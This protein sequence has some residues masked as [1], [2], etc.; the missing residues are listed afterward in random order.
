MQIE[1]T[2]TN[3][4]VRCAALV[5]I[6]L[7]SASVMAADELDLRTE[8]ILRWFPTNT[9]ALAVINGEYD[10]SRT[11]AVNHSV[12]NLDH[13]RDGM[14]HSQGLERIFKNMAVERWIVG[15]EWP[16]SN[17]LLSPET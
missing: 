5:A 6:T 9:E 1:V 4:L 16:S 7:G 13:A 17:W 10:M 2:N 11:L 14:L 12:T 15:Q 3:V 8:S